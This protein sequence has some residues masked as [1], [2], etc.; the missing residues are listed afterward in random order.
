MENLRILFMGT[1]DFA[2]CSLKFLFEAGENIV[3][4]ITGE[5][6]AK[7]RGLKIA[8]SPVKEYANSKALPVYQPATLKNNAIAD[9]LALLQ[10]DIITVVA[11]GKL[12][13]EYVINYPK[14]GCI[15]VH[16]SLLPEYRGAAPI[17][18][19]VI[20]GKTAT[21]ITTMFM[22]TS[23]DTGDIIFTKKTEIGE[24]ETVGELWDRLAQMGGELLVK[25]VNAIKDGDFPRIKQDDSLATYAPK[26]EKTETH[27]DFSCD[28][29]KVHDKIRGLSPFPS[30]I[31]NIDGRPAKI[32]DTEY[33]KMQHDKKPGEIISLS[34]GGVTVACGHDCIK[35]RKIKPEGSKALS[36]G[37]LINGRKLNF[38]SI[39]S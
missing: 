18:R 17:Q 10:P 8:Y 14:Y 3:G 20:D 1:P 11:Y 28:A 25:T 22:D 7:G 37:D 24:N 31:C 13:P 36:V 23:L 4:V 26:I 29:K 5:D 15:N 35:I 19:A 6:K 9:L 27:V 16:G 34:C 39:F 38:E 2:M 33:I 30:A 12:L 32:Y 21:G